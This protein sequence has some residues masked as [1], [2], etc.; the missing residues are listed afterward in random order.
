MRVCACPYSQQISCKHNN[1]PLKHIYTPMLSIYNVP[2]TIL[3]LLI[4]GAIAVLWVIRLSN[5]RATDV[6]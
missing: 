3:L 1:R 6:F 4:L 2:W 5:A